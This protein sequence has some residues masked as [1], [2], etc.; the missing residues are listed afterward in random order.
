MGIGIILKF[1]SMAIIKNC[2]FFVIMKVLL[3]KL[4]MGWQERKTRKIVQ[5]ATIL[6][7]L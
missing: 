3:P 5:F 7:F 2:L 6:H 1:V 4:Q